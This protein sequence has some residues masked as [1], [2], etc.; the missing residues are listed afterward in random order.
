MI[1]PEPFLGQLVEVVFWDHSWT[2]DET[3]LSECRIWGRLYKANWKRIIIQVWE[4]GNS[5][6]D[7][8]E[9]AIIVRGAISSIT[10]LERTG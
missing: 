1:Q 5:S 6:T 2:D 9:Y 8:A 10:R 7:D 4:T 3:D